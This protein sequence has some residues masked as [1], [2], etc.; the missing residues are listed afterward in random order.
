MP[1]IMSVG[2]IALM[3]FHL[4]I[5]RIFNQVEQFPHAFDDGFRVR[6]RDAV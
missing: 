4:P 6:Y 5:E 2:R 3:G 1:D